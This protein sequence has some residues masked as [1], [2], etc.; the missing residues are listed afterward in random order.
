MAKANGEFLGTDQGQSPES[1]RPE[2]YF[3]PE[4]RAAVNSLAFVWDPALRRKNEAEYLAV[5]AGRG[6][7]PEEAWNLLPILNSNRRPPII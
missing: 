6:L 2:P 7:S 5:A 4:L 1:P 3:D